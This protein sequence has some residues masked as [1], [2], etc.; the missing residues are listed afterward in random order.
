MS[1]IARGVFVAVAVCV[2]LASGS[3]VAQDRI[4]QKDSLGEQQEGEIAS[5]EL[6]AGEGYYVTLEIPQSISLPVE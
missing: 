5:A 4:V 1:R 6:V 2:L 3:A